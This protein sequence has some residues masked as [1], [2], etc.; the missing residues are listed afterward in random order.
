MRSSRSC[1]DTCCSDFERGPSFLAPSKLETRMPSTVLLKACNVKPTARV[2]SQPDFTER[3]C[4][5]SRCTIASPNLSRS[6]KTQSK[7]HQRNQ[8]PHQTFNV[9]KQRWHQTTPKLTIYRTASS[10]AGEYD[11]TRTLDRRQPIYDLRRV[12]R[13]DGTF[14]FL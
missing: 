1:V 13:K 5:L 2:E 8:R 12:P 4:Y 7:L 6:T 14:Q 11:A 9:N 3:L 10:R